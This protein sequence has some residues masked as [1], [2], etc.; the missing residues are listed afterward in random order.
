MRFTRNKTMKAKTPSLGRLLM[1]IHNDEDGG[2]S[3]ETVL[4]IGVI[5][6]PILLL[7]VRFGIPAIWDYFKKGAGDVGITV[8]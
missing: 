6:L 7:L 8:P 1:Q 2:V 4:I 3:L 5:A